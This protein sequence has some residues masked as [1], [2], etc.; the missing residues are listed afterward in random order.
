MVIFQD[1]QQKAREE[2]IEIL[3]D[4]PVDIL[5]SADQLK[6]MTYL[7]QIINE[8]LRINGPAVTVL[9]RITAEDT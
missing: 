4:Q 3:G 9:P 8:N 6:K 2:V 1:I 7:Q 5:P